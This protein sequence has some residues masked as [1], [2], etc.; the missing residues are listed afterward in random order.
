M[1]FCGK[2]EVGGG[3]VVRYAS[4]KSKWMDTTEKAMAREEKMLDR[5]KIISDNGG[6]FGEESEASSQAL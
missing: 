4:E 5:R 2:E 1:G 6:E 3:R